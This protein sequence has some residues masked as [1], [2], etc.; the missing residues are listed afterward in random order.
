MSATATMRGVV[1]KG[2]T[3]TMREGVCAEARL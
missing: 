2:A 1:Y 3:A